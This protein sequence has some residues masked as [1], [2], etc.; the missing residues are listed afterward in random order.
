MRIVKRADGTVVIDKSGK[1]GGRG[2][3]LHAKCVEAAIKKRA[4]NAAFKCNVKQD[5][6]DA[7]R[8]I[9]NLDGE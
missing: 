5:V 4:L 7:L 9:N 8:E 3:Y 6:Y 1:A 2:V